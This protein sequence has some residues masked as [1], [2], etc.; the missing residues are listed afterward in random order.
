MEFIVNV[1]VLSTDR[2]PAASATPKK[3]LKPRHD[4]S[5]IFIRLLAPE[6]FFTDSPVVLNKM[7][8]PFDFAVA[9]LVFSHCGLDLIVSWVSSITNC[10]ASIGALV[11]TFFTGETDNAELGW[12]YPAASVITPIPSGW[13]REKRTCNSRSWI[14]VIRGRLGRCSRSRTWICL[15][16][17]QTADLEHHAGTDR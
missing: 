6:I 10:L 15:V 5:R 3:L 1:V 9:Q 8:I 11:S 12:T 16:P 14:G 2:A 13:S 4:R 7:K 17:E